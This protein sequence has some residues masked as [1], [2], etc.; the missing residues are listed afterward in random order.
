SDLRPRRQLVWRSLP[1][2][3]LTLLLGG[4]TTWLTAWRFAM[5]GN[6]GEFERAT[7][8]IEYP[9]LSYS[10]AMIH[11]SRHTAPGRERLL[12]V[13]TE[14]PPNSHK[15]VTAFLPAWSIGRGDYLKQR[16][17]PMWVPPTPNPNRAWSGAPQLHHWAEHA[18]GWPSL[19]LRWQLTPD[20]KLHHA[21]E[22][23]TWAS[24]L[25]PTGPY[26][27]P[28]TGF[29]DNWRRSG[30]H[31]LPYQ[32]HWPGFALDTLF[33]AFVWLALTGLAWC[34]RRGLR[35]ACGRCPGCGYT[36][37]HCAAPGCP[38][39]GWGRAARREGVAS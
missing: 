12:V 29:G 13:V 8:Q 25:F 28:P 39:C 30:R 36:L 10:S 2:L 15:A 24:L 7:L 16:F 17:P 23:P 19:C 27:A 31:Q 35:H 14:P 26:D 38:E 4:V 32:L 11:L 20:G 5:Y 9:R 1:L 33:F 3:A 37:R 18:A 22:A 21:L 6:A 34:G